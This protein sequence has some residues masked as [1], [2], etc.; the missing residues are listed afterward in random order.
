MITGHF[1]SAV[2]PLTT[3]TIHGA[4]DPQGSQ[5]VEKVTGRR[6]ESFALGHLLSDLL[7]LGSAF[8]RFCHL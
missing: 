8:Y 1:Q 3:A 7:A 2:V 6:L 5:E 4:E